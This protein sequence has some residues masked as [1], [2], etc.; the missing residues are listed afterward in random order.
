M[1]LPLFRGQAA[2]FYNTDMFKAAGLNA[3]PKTM[4]EYNAVRREADEARR[5]WQSDCL[6][7]EPAPHRRR[8]GHRREVLDQPVPVWRLSAGTD[9]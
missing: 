7:L 2:L 5:R 6:R 1:A 8:A 3:P 9:G 4:E